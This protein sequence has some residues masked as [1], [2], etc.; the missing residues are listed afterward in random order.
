M[1]RKYDSIIFDLDGTLWDAAAEVYEAW[2][3]I[4][5]SQPDVAQLPTKEDM[6]SIMGLSNDEI[7]R[8]LFPQLDAKRGFELFD[9]CCE[10]EN[11]LLAKRGGRAYPGIEKTLEALSREYKLCIVSN[12]NIGYIDSYFASMNTKDYFI[13]SENFGR[14]G[15]PK[16]DNIKL[17]IERNG[18]KNPVYVGDT[19]WDKNSAD[20]AGVPFIFASYGFGR[21]EGAEVTI[22]SPEELLDKIN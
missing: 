18:F 12:C 7:V 3:F 20:S 4:L 19:I 16:A 2:I 14:T 6:E 5:K 1:K 11:Q 17:V 13:D 22:N 10:Y 8:K 15:K 21:V 9:A